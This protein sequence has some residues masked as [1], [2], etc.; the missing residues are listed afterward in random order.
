[1]QLFLPPSCTQPNNTYN[2]FLDARQ[3]RLTEATRPFKARGIRLDR[4][5][6]CA[7][8]LCIC[9]H[10]QHHLIPLDL[11]VIYHRDELLKPT[12]TGRLIADCFPG[13]TWTAIWSRT[14][15]CSA[16]TALLAQ[17]SSQMALLFP[18]QDHKIADINA[19]KTSLAAQ[20]PKPDSHPNRP[21]LVILDG[22]WKQAQKM[23]RQ[24]PWLK[25]I[26]TLPLP[27]H[28][29]SKYLLRQ[30]AHGGQLST[31]EAVANAMQTLGL[32]QH[33]KIL[34]NYFNIFRSHYRAMRSNLRSPIIE[35]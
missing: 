8:S 21:M 15:S 23:Y 35:G 24:T 16:M 7:L 14:G 31:A 1:M 13:N 4:C 3:Q 19:L 34:V 20:C 25:S 5:D 12:N 28:G 17:R 29:A 27:P 26:P 33:S 10:R 6:R 18:G 9:G 22:T 11:L 32:D 30:A 2:S